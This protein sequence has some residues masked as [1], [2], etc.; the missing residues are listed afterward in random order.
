[1]K[2]SPRSC[3]VLELSVEPG[4]S[5]WAELHAYT[6]PRKLAA[7][8]KRFCKNE[9]GF[10]AYHAIWYGATLGIWVVQAG[11]VTR[12]VDLH[13]WISARR[14]RGE[15][16]P[17]A[18][19]AALRRAL[20]LGAPGEPYDEDLPAKVKLAVDWDE[21]AALLP[22]L[23]QPLLRRGEATPVRRVRGARRASYLEDEVQF[24]SV[25]PEE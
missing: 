25:D 2:P 22:A 12:F 21:V 19:K 17:L 6:D 18:R 10:S 13:P 5:R 20:D 14:G 1:M 8:V 16:V 15:A 23:K 11:V 9:H 24:G 7:L 4:G 3:Y